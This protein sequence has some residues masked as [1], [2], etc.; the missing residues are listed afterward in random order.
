MMQAARRHNPGRAVAA[1]THR[2]VR[3]LLLMDTPRILAEAEVEGT[4]ALCTAT[5][6]GVQCMQT[7]VVWEQGGA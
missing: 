1:F 6:D 7:Q 2:G 5:A 3:P 4:T